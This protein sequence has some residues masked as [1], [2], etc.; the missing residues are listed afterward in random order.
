MKIKAMIVLTLATMAGLTIAWIDARPNWD[1]TGISVLMIL[2]TA[3]LFS[4]F[5]PQR[6]WLTAL[7]VCIWIPI[8]GIIS[9]QNFGSMIAVIPGFIGAYFGYF[10]KRGFKS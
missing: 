1:D 5:S 10:V 3:T 2:C 9:S 8:W 6:P 7:A 4:Y